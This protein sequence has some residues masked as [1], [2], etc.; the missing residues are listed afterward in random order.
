MSARHL[1]LGGRRVLITGGAQ[2]IGGAIARRFAEEGARVAVNDLRRSTALT[3][4]L[5]SLAPVA[6]GAHGAF[7]ADVADESAVARMVE[8]VIRDFGGIDILVNNAAIQLGAASDAM[9][10]EQFDRVLSVNLRGVFLCCRAVLQHF[11]GTGTKGT[12]LNTS[13][14][15]AVIPKPGFLGYSVSKGGLGNLTRTLALEYAGRGI[16]V[17]DVA[18]GAIATPLNADWVGDPARRAAVERHIPMARV[19]TPEEVAGLFAF[20]ASDEAAYITGQTFFIDGGLNLYGDF[21]QNW[22]S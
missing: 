17:N 14:V 18:P 13:S 6:A 8:A 7:V 3:E 4:T 19:G 2:G 21:A 9:T 22:S 1:R 11:L 10:L 15:H 20:L 16:R 12:I 5:S